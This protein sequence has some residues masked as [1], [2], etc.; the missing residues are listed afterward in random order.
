MQN[1]TQT[2]SVEIDLADRPT[3]VR[4]LVLVFVAFASSSAYL[5][6][7]SIAVANTSIQKDLGFT[8]EQMGWVLG[9]FA[10]GYLF[11]QIPGGWLGNRIGTRGALASLSI[12]WSALTV[13]TGAST[14]LIAM[15]SSRFAFGAAQAGLVP[16]SARVIKDWFPLERRGIYSSLIAASM[17]VGGAFTLYLTGQL[18]QV[19]YWRA[20]FYL[21]SLVGVIWA[22]GF[23]WFF[24]TRPEEHPWV[25]ASELSLIRAELSDS[26]PDPAESTPT[27]TGRVDTAHQQPSP[28]ASPV[29]GAHATI[30]PDAG[31]VASSE[32][33]SVLSVIAASFKKLTM[34]GICIQSF[35]RAAGYAFYVTW[36]PAFLEYRFNLTNERAGAMTTWPVLLVVPGSISGGFVVDYLLRRTGSRRLS[37]SGV[38]F[39]ALA[40]CGVLTWLSARAQAPGQLVGVMALGALFSGL[41][42]PA[43]WAATID[44]AGR[45]PAVIMA[46]MNTAGCLTGIVTTYVGYQIADIQRTGGNWNE[47]IYLHVGFYLAAA[48]AFLF[49]DPNQTVTEA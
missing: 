38:A 31:P 35:F 29:G 42:G 9:A 17:S 40:T 10:W 16:N 13:V 11:F 22:V 24:R 27:D 46:V 25:S 1:G 6:R 39:M 48:T 23:Y 45:Q 8:N 37:R 19:L 15:W 30:Q 47:V 36:L 18:L 34:W 14:T 32:D 7:H 4:Y 28:T 2:A 43:A 33:P 3:Q 26:E 21:Y 5:T 12:L 41:A 44:V 49:V 20:I